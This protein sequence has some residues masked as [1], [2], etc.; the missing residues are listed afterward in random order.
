M[1]PFGNLWEMKTVVDQQ[2]REDERIAF[3]AGNFTEL[4]Q[5]TYT[6]YERLVEPTVLQIGVPA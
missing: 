6:D 1:P 4:I 3:N 2:L 5:L